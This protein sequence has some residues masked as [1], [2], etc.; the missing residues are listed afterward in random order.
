MAFP[1]F[2]PIKPPFCLLVAEKAIAMSFGGAIAIRAVCDRYLSN[3]PIVMVEMDQIVSGKR[4]WVCF[5]QANL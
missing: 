4:G 2:Y 3:H 5:G 1:R